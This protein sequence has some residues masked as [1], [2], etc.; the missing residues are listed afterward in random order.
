MSIGIH[1]DADT[2]LMG[3]PKPK[4]QQGYHAHLLFP[5]RRILL[6]GDSGTDDA[7]IQGFGA[8]LSVLSNRRTSAGIVEAMNREWSVL[9]N[10]LVAEVGLTADYDWR[11]YERLGID[12][13][14]QPRLTQKQVALEKK[15][16]F[17]RQGDT[18]RDILVM[19][20]VYKNTHTEVLVAHR[21]QAQ[22]DVVRESVTVR[23]PEMAIEAP[24]VPEALGAP[25]TDSVDPSL[26]QEL[27]AARTRGQQPDAP[28]AD[29]F[30]AHSPM[31]TDENEREILFALSGLVWSIQKALRTLGTLMSRLLGHREQISRTSAGDLD[32]AFQL[33]EA[34]RRQVKTQARLEQYKKEHKWEMRLRMGARRTPPEL[35]QIQR[36][37]DLQQRTMDSLTRSRKANGKALAAL[38][39]EEQEL[40]EYQDR[41]QTRLASSVAEFRKLDDC[42]LPVLLAVLPEEQRVQVE[43]LVGEGRAP[44][45]P[46]TIEM[47][48]PRLALDVP[49]PRP[50]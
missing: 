3:N 12:R 23:G 5:T 14:P 31:P 22:A 44:T 50:H 8:K 47:P 18:L 32:E 42:A 15:G 24:E 35:V 34:W 26:A 6:E 9:A 41:I 37:R 7:A 17:T 40:I 36:D 46:L 30:V 29:R 33:D 38:R 4:E 27:M 19:S 25:D 39:A 43:A 1:R 28:L 10:E 13:V 11:R 16:F 48:L 49:R 20:E 2:D 21:E 45:K